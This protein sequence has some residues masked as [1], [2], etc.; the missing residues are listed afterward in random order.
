MPPKKLR[1]VPKPI[2]NY[3]TREGICPACDGEGFVT[4]EQNTPP[5]EYHITCEECNGS[6]KC[7][8]CGDVSP[9]TPNTPKASE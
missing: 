6:G 5:H 3:C 9:T 4:A 7:P 8:M 2:C 1:N